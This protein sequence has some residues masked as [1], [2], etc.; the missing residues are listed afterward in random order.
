MKNS[1]LL[2]ASTL[3]VAFGQSHENL[4]AVAW[5]QRAAEYRGLTAQ[6]YQAARPALD[7]ALKDKT[8]TAALEQQAFDKKKLK[9]LPPAIILDLDE[10]VLDNTPYQVGLIAAGPPHDRFT[11]PAWQAWVDRAKAKTLPGAKE[12][13]DYANAKKVAIF[14]VTNRV[15]DPTKTTDATVTVLTNERLPLAPG[16]LVCKGDTSNKS[17]RRAA[18]AEKYRIALL[19]GDDLND[20]VP[21]ESGGLDA[22]DAAANANRD[23]WGKQWFLLPNPM[24]GS[25]ERAVGYGVQQKR[26]ALRP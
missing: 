10:T 11:D 19:F 15:C 20:F 5:V 1:L 16:R 4:N 23:K 17:P 13:L 22:R 9:K 14:Y 2:L 3:V 24:Y 21:A 25:W 18:I 8:S 7:Q 6:A 26:D 12:F